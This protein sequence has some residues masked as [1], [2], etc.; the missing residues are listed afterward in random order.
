MSRER[1]GSVN[2]ASHEL[3]EIP[4]SHRNVHSTS[5]G[6]SG[7]DW[8]SQDSLDPMPAVGYSPLSVLGTGEGSLPERD[9]TMGVGTAAPTLGSQSFVGL[10]D[11]SLGSTPTG[12]RHE[13][14][15]IP[16]SHRNVHSTHMIRTIISYIPTWLRIMRE[17]PRL[18]MPD[19]P[20]QRSRAV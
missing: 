11:Q 12:P 3:V 10:A 2:D 1:G 4:T 19:S 9:Q 16:T 5:G 15:E 7:L 18:R 20:R 6:E 13:L 8:Y 14:V 17:R